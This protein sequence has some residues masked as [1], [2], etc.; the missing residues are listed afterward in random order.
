M[1]TGKKGI[2]FFL[3]LLFLLSAAAPLASAAETEPESEALPACAETGA[4]EVAQWSPVGDGT[5]DDA[6]HAG[7]R[8]FRFARL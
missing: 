2:C 8:R 6:S 5:H 3:A 1:N 7:D 4:H